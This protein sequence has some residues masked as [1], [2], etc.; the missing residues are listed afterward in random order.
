M[1]KVA[2]TV[3]I[4]R[5]MHVY[6]HSLPLVVCLLL[7]VIPVI[8]QTGC[9]VGTARCDSAGPASVGGVAVA[10][11]TIQP[12]DHNESTASTLLSDSKRSATCAPP[13]AGPQYDEY[14]ECD[15]IC[16]QA[17]S[18]TGPSSFPVGVIS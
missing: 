9:G 14:R 4:A 8:G 3:L 11:D 2:S 7:T 10:G 12:A 16:E 17:R 1:L 15:W 6:F 18:G 5:V 13:V